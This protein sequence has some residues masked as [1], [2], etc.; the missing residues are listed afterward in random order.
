[1]D[2]QFVMGIDLF[3]KAAKAYVTGDPL[4]EGRVL[5]MQGL[6]ESEAISQA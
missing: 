5:P 4:N 1:M 3:I 2:L 6:Q